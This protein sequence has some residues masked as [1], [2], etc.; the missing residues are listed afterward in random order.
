MDIK[1]Q[2]EGKDERRQKKKGNE[3]IMIS[4]TLVFA[5]RFQVHVCLY[6]ICMCVYMHAIH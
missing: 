4:K 2:N 6:C 5:M 1:K 3:P